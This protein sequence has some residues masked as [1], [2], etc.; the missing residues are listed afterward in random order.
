MQN[1]LLADTVHICKIAAMNI[2]ETRKILGLTQSELGKKMGVDGSIISKME[3]GTLI[4]GL[5]TLLAME[6]LVT[7]SKKDDK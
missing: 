6:A 3:K 4:V 2:K 7:R 5:R 1:K